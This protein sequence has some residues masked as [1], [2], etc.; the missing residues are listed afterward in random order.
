MSENHKIWSQCD[1]RV[2]K[3]VEC[4]P[5]PDSENLYY[6]KIDLGEGELR[7]IGS[8]L[9]KFVKLETMTEGLVIVFAN[10]KPRKLADF[11]SNGMVMCASNADHTAVEIMRPPANAKIGDRVQL[12]GNPINGQ[13]LT[14]ERQSVLNPK[15]K[16]E[17]KLLELLTTNGDLEALYDG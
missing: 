1:L 6:E 12:M 14:E 15:R 9:Q 16:I 8:G 17:R 3:I 4:K 5:H 11:M 2:G 7:E 13:P 10:L